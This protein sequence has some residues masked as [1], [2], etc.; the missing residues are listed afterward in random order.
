M[1]LSYIRDDVWEHE[2]RVAK[3]SYACPNPNCCFFNPKGFTA[4]VTCGCKFTFKVVTGPSKV[5]LP[6]AESMV[7]NEDITAQEYKDYGLR[8][9]KHALR[10]QHQK[11]YV[12]TDGWLL[13]QQVLRCLD[14]RR[15]WDLA[16]TREDNLNKLQK[17]G[18]RWHTGEQWERPSA[19]AFEMMSRNPPIGIPGV[20]EFFVRHRKC[21][22]DKHQ[23]D[24]KFIATVY[25]VGLMC[26]RLEASFP[27]LVHR[28]KDWKL[29]ELHCQTGVRRDTPSVP[30]RLYRDAEVFGRSATGECQAG[31][32]NIRH[33]G[34]LD[35]Q[36]AGVALTKERIAEI[37]HA[38]VKGRSHKA[39]L[40]LFHQKQKS[41]NPPNVSGALG[42]G[43][44]S[45]SGVRFPHTPRRSPS[46]NP[47]MRDPP[48]LK[49]PRVPFPRTPPGDPQALRGSA[50][51]VFLVED[52]T[53]SL[54][55]RS[56]KFEKNKLRPPL[57]TD[58]TLMLIS[59]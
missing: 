3:D 22:E 14:W 15:K 43:A 17:G 38:I 1:A 54:P 36:I 16:W 21:L 41:Q 4:C 5:A 11:I 7:G 33:A 27:D 18:S 44:A 10:A 9:A 24:H 2:R 13:W 49:A 19:L 12:Y 53:T 51:R 30:R 47:P 23:L 29:V 46:R 52:L 50:K 34:W 58:A 42:L 48:V 39:A 56:R 55:L 6:L 32:E 26:D 37:K 31:D 45:S 57:H 25:T 28:L 8:V 40:E 35:Q 20:T 59:A